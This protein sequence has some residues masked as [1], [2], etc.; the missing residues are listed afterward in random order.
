[1]SA[2][3]IAGQ[4]A[5]LLA[6]IRLGDGLPIVWENSGVINTQYNA[7]VFSL[8]NSADGVNPLRFGVNTTTGVIRLNG[9]TGS[10]DPLVAPIA[11]LSVVG[12]MPIDIKGVRYF[13]DLKQ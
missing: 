11:A 12:Q 13:I 6:A 8:N 4:Q 9:I 3:A 5:R 1:M 7:G 2:I 10:L